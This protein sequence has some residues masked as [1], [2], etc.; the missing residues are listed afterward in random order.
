[1]YCKY[2]GAQ[3]EDR[4]S[5]C[6]TCGRVIQEAP[7][8][9]PQVVPH[10]PVK[11]YLVPAILATIFCCQ[12]LGIVSIV[13]AASAQSKLSSGDYAGAEASADTARKWFWAAFGIGLGWLALCFVFVVIMALVGAMN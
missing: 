9:A 1:M 5:V 2:C 10:R 11:T 8:A 7:A 13:F 12:P 4:A 6:V 3:N